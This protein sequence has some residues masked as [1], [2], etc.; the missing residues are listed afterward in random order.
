MALVAYVVDIKGSQPMRSE[1]AVVERGPAPET[2][3]AGS[4]ARVEYMG[5]FAAMILDHQEDD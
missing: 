4:P 3:Q 2:T 1:M 5:D